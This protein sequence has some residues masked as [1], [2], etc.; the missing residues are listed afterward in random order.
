MGFFSGENTPKVCAFCMTWFDF[1]L[2]I[3]K[4]WKSLE[5]PWFLIFLIYTG[6]GLRVSPFV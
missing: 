5:T 4:A 3:R 2:Y 1:F 6:L